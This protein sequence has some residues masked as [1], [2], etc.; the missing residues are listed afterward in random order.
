[1]SSVQANSEYEPEDWQLVKTANPYECTKYQTDLLAGYFEEQQ[2]AYSKKAYAIN[3]EDTPSQRKS[4]RHILVQPGVVATSIF[5]GAMYWWL[6]PAMIGFFYFV[7]SCSCS[8]RLTQQS[9]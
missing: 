6:V 4:I 2:R 5:H 9:Y 7:S 1:M 8:V 3:K